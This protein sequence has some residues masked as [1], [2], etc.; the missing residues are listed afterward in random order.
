MST[1]IYAHRGFERPLKMLNGKY[2][3]PTLFGG[4]PGRLR[5]GDTPNV[6]ASNGVVHVIDRRRSDQAP[7]H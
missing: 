2:T 3:F 4:R 6:A 5:Q 1:D 7:R